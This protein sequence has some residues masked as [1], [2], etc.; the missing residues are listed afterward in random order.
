MTIAEILEGL[1]DAEAARGDALDALQADA[2]TLIDTLD[3]A[4][5][6]AQTAAERG[7]AAVSATLDA[8]PAALREVVAGF[9][10]DAVSCA[11]AADSLS[12][13]SS[14]ALPAGLVGVTGTAVGETISATL[15]SLRQEAEGQELVAQ[16]LSTYADA[17]DE[18]VQA[19][20]AEQTR[21][22]GGR[23]TLAGIQVP[24]FGAMHGIFGWDSPFHDDFDTAREIAGSAL[25]ALREVFSAVVDYRTALSALQDMVGPT[26]V[27]LG[28]ANGYARVGG[29]IAGGAPVPAGFTPLDLMTSHYSS[30]PDQPDAS[31]LSDTEWAHFTERWNSLSDKEREELLAAMSGGAD[32]RVPALV[33]SALAT[34]APLAA[35]L[36]LASR[37]KALAATPEGREVIS[38][39]AGLDL[40]GAAG[41]AEPGVP[42]SGN[43]LDVGGEEYDQEG[44]TCA[45]T[46][47]LLLASQTDPFLALIIA[48]GEPV[49]GYWPEVLENVAP[50]DLQ[51]LTPAERFRLLQ[52]EA[53]NYINQGD[54][55]LQWSLG[56]DPMDEPGSVRTGTEAVTGTTLTPDDAES[57]AEMTR[58][59]DAGQPVAISVTVGD[60]GDPDNNGGH[61]VLVVGHENGSYQVYEPNTGV[62]TV[63]AEDMA[64]GVL[65]PEVVE[66]I[67]GDDR[68][69]VHDGYY[70][71]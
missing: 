17:L 45:S 4:V 9:R 39:V 69:F 16:H 54:P 28:D 14:V 3:H 41:A 68:F 24:D 65:P 19:Q 48:T 71:P 2:G 63:S 26:E 42:G 66:S 12:A 7:C 27:A 43:V 36:A 60:S 70:L 37:L 51:G 29:V 44:P 18:L 10:S 32:G 1:D 56:D 62:W 40:A 35:V 50:A 46:D 58:T 20:T 57:L 59:V 11:S 61:Q 34:G 38:E 22:E 30:S 67:F 13:V 15:T 31:I 5:G 33:M 53:R 64:A 52:V 49:D 55:D 47:L 23:S 8:D 21:A 25:E 6:L